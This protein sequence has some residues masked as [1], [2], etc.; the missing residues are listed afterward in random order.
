MQ[1]SPSPAPDPV[2]QAMLEEAFAGFVVPGKFASGKRIGSG[3]I[4]DTFLVETTGGTRF[5]LQRVNTEVFKDFGGLMNN[6]RVVTQHLEKKIAERKTDTGSFVPLR[7]I[8]SSGGDYHHTGPDGS[9]WRMYNHIEGSRSYDIVKD[10]HLAHEAGMA[11]GLFQLLAS[12]IPAG[13]LV[14]T[15]PFFHDI[16][17][18]L[19]RFR[20]TVKRDPVNRVKDVTEEIEFVEKRAAAM[21]RILQLGREGKIPLRVTHNDTKINNVLFDANDRALCVV[22]LDTVMPGYV[23]YDFGDAIRTGANRCAED[24]A[25][26]SK[27]GIDL[28]LFE[29]WSRGYLSIARSFLNDYEIENLAFSAIVMTYIIGLR[30]LTDHI[31]GDHYYRISFPGHN[32]RRARVQ[33]RFIESME[34]NLD[35][36]QEKI[37]LIKR[38]LTK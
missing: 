5:V 6:I 32:L 26:P 21:G 33:F 28:A 16:E 7:L 10:P 24:E 17:K 19:E 4:N 14:E 20:E 8:P 3:H 37:L 11:Y 35:V 12:D 27:A 29:A 38:S 2:S 13:E 22:D 15:I 23:L 1:T 9:C 31:D 18:R 36:M 30:F 25:D 34:E